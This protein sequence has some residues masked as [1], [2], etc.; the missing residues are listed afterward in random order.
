M[1]L[2]ET[3]TRIVPTLKCNNRKRSLIFFEHHL[4]MTNLLEDGAWTSL[5]D[6]SRVEKLTLEEAPS[7]RTRATKGTKKLAK[8]VIKVSNPHEIEALLARGSSYTKLYRGQAGYAFETLSPEGDCI[9]LHA[10]EHSEILEEIARADFQ[11]DTLFT[12]LTRFEVEQITLNVPN[13]TASQ[14]FY[15][16]LFPNLERISFLQAEGDDLQVSAEETWD[17][18]QLK[19]VVTGFDGTFDG[20]SIKE[21]FPAAFLPKSGKFVALS[22]LSQIELWVEGL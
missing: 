19:F 16:S 8:L 11:E 2:I 21:Q 20:I 14:D 17:V 4:G 5:G 22:D 3:V 7:N 6:K 12:G 13:V 9:L 18:S 15:K 10:E 1:K